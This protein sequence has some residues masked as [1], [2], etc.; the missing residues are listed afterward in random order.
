MNAALGAELSPEDPLVD[1]RFGSSARAQIPPPRANGPADGR[2]CEY[3]YE[4]NAQKAGLTLSR[5]EI[6][7]QIPP[8]S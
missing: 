1:L 3:I 2:D 4:A 8:R 6:Y 5:E 7:P